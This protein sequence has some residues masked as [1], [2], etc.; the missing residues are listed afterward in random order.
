MGRDSLTGDADEVPLIGPEI[1]ELLWV[2]YD[3]PQTTKSTLSKTYADEI[4]IA[5]CAGLITVQ[6]GRSFGRVWRITAFGLELL[7][8]AMDPELT[9]IKHEILEDYQ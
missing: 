5:C 8:A 7:G 4:A 1:I 6:V 2:I 9:N 3:T